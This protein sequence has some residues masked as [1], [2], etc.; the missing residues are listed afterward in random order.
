MEKEFDEALKLLGN[1]YEE[2][3]DCLNNLECQQEQKEFSRLFEILREMRDLSAVTM[4]KL[5]FTNPN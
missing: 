5:H 1:L 2:G 4:Q 3:K